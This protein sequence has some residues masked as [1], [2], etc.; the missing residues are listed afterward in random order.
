MFS[1]QLAPLFRPTLCVA[2]SAARRLPAHRALSSTSRLLSATNITEADIDNDDDSLDFSDSNETE[3]FQQFLDEVAW[4]YRNAEPQNWLGNTPF[5]M[6]PSFRPPPPISDSQREAM[7]R[8]FMSD[9]EGNSVRVLSQR[10]NLSIKRVDAILRLK[11]MERDWRQVGS[12]CVFF[13]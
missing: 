6:N 5:P 3:T 2:R 10:Y 13:S 7:Y 12:I 1:H 8:E 4:R 9:P 11:G